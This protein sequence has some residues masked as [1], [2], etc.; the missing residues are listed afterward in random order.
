VLAGIYCCDLGV[1]LLAS[2]LWIG[3]ILIENPVNMKDI[4]HASF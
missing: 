3:L 2:L 1:M 4:K